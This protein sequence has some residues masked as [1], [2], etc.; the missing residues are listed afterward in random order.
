MKSRSFA[1]FENAIKSAQTKT[2]YIGSLHQFMRFAKI[3]EYDSITKRTTNEIQNILENWVMEL[4]DQG[5]KANTIKTK[6]NA[7]ELFLEMNRIVFHK[8]VLH[9][10]I[11]SEDY[12]PGGQKPFTT[13][14]IRKMLSSTTKHRTKALIHYFASTGSRP[15]SIADPVL[16]VKHLEEM[17][18]GCK[19]MRIYDG[20][21]E[22]YWA[23]LT[24]EAT[25]ALHDYLDARE[26]S[27]EEIDQETPV[28]ANSEK[29]HHRKK[30][31][32]LSEKSARQIISNL[33]NHAGIERTK[34]GY[35]YDKAPVYGFRKRFNTIL[36]LNNDVNSNIAEKLMAHKRG[37]DGTYLQ[38]TR[39]ECFAEFKKAIEQLT[40]DPT[41]RQLQQI[42]SLEHEKSEIEELKQRID[43][44]E[45]TVKG[46]KD[47]ISEIISGETIPNIHHHDITI[48]EGKK[49]LVA[50][51][52][53]KSTGMFRIGCDK[54]T[55][56]T[57]NR[58]KREFMLLRLGSIKKLTKSEKYELVEQIRGAVSD[59]KQ[60][61]MF[62]YMSEEEVIP[63]FIRLMDSY[64]PKI[65]RE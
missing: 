17:S 49:Q 1:L 19:S 51:N 58:T 45:D 59:L 63:A 32:H 55:E 50:K 52:L 16:R 48:R 65:I 62:A 26:L 42:R 60:K 12:I 22:G 31:Q 2:V 35:R 57:L 23:F 38:P 18:D 56:R 30:V 44:Y 61:D 25:R 47:L 36:K 21:K 8:R 64:R 6:L 24:P 11:P 37:L 54:C 27:G 53:W 28:F 20:S 9:K 41:Q 43:V 5:L 34:N 33:L 10:L 3:K 14:E 39:E 46:F 13:E 15:A 4:K 40:I 29:T 7:V